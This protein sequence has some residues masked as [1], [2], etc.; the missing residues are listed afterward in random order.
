[1]NSHGSRRSSILTALAFA[2]LVYG[3]IVQEAAHSQPLPGQPPAAQPPRLAVTGPGAFELDGLVAQALENN[4]EIKAARSELS[5]AE[6]RIRPAGALDDPMLEAGVLNVPLNSLSF[7]REDMTMKMLGLSQRLPFPGK[8]ALREE[9]ASRDADMIR[10]G[11]AETQNRV[12]REV[13]VVYYDLALVVQSMRI[14][15]NN[16]RVLEQFL[17]TAEARYA[18]GQASQS[19][20]LKA[21][22]QLS[23]MTDE[24]IRLERELATMEADLN[25][26]LGR[27]GGV[28]VE[29]GAIA[30]PGE[31]RLNSQALLDEAFAERPQLLGLQRAIARADR[32]IEL[33]RLDYYPDFDVKLSY[34]K[35]EPMP[36]GA[37]R[38]DM[39]AL[40]VSINLP[41]WQEAKRDPRLAEA[42]A[43]RDQARQMLEAS[44]NELAAKLRQQVAL[45]DQSSRSAH[46]YRAAILPPAR[47]AVEAGFEAY[48]VG[49]VD[50]LTL[51]DSQM[52]VFNLETSLVQTQTAL[53]KA[54]AEIRFLVG[55]GGPKAAAPQTT[56]ASQ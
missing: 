24:R 6:Q 33:A 4:P 1:M 19:D 55:S 41:V 30:A 20:V 29:P 18:V 14:V 44:R 45:A 12:V 56:G 53:A 34:G 52:A 2:G 54:L 23:K 50:F 51:L 46:L 31:L 25:R 38:D 26:L 35:R 10:F 3:S 17:K 11:Y 13:R 15:Q 47:L 48:R 37:R 9:V 49:R 8:R 27:T 5:A 7:R 42:I 21:Q 40:T 36:D 39:V 28:A 16:T 43:M 32:T 22:T